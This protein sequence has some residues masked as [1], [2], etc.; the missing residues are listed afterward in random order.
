MQLKILK[1]QL[2]PTPA[3]IYAGVD[4]PIKIT[5][6]A[7]N[8]D[9][10]EEAT[11]TVSIGNTKAQIFILNDDDDEVKMIV[12]NKKVGNQQERHSIQLRFRLKKTPNE[13]TAV[14]I[15]LSGQNSLGSTDD[16]LSSVICL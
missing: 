6:V 13:P 12:I 3:Y 9:P 16:K 8:Q 7:L 5:F 11:F 1:L 4:L 10:V 15:K 14:L 2:A